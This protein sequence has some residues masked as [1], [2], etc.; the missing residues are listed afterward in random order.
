MPNAEGDDGDY[1]HF[2]LSYSASWLMRKNTPKDCDLPALAADG[3]FEMLLS[4]YGNKAQKRGQDDLRTRLIYFQRLDA[5]HDFHP[6]FIQTRSNL[7]HIKYKEI[8]GIPLTTL[9]DLYLKAFEEQKVSMKE[10]KEVFKHRE[11]YIKHWES[12]EEGHRLIGSGEKRRFDSFLRGMVDD[13]NKILAQKRDNSTTSIGRTAE[14]F[15]N[16]TSVSIQL[17]DRHSSPALTV[18]P[19]LV[20]FKSLSKDNFALSEL[21]E[22]MKRHHRSPSIS[23]TS[24][25]S[26]K[27]MSPKKN[28]QSRTFFDVKKFDPVEMI[29]SDRFKSKTSSIVEPKT[30]EVSITGRCPSASFELTGKGPKSKPDPKRARTNE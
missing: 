3:V 2:E 20:P 13:L 5:R 22:G 30:L 6:A 18:P 19:P 23:P 10:Q 8:K 12:V 9:E 25:A 14:E 27:F 26:S 21:T 16:G 15:E 11:A 17:L 7:F 24:S 1:S 29:P 28:V 4:R